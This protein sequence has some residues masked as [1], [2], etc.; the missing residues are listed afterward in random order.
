MKCAT[1]LTPVD[2]EE[3]LATHAFI[4]IWVSMKTLRNSRNYYQ[5]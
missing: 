5:W 3:V 1:Q 2:N 4:W